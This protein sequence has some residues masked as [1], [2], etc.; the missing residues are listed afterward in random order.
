M[1]RAKGNTDSDAATTRPGDQSSVCD[2]A[3]HISTHA[4]LT[5][6]ASSIVEEADIGMNLFD[7]EPSF[8]I[9]VREE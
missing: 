3:S 5:V 6:N 8:F 9:N 4:N 1:V 7:Q 2:Q